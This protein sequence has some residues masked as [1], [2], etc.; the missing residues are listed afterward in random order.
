MENSDKQHVSIVIAGHIDAGKSSFTGRLLYDMGNISQRE[1]DKLQAEADALGKGSF[2]FAFYTDNQKAERERGITINYNC[3]DF[4]T[5]KYHYT[6]IDAP[7]HRDFVK[8][9][10]SGSSTADTAIIMVPADS[11]TVAMAKKNKDEGT[12]EGQ[13]RQHSLILYLLGIKQLIVQVNK[14]DLVNYSEEKFNEIKAEVQNMLINVGW[15]KPFVMNNVPIIPISAWHGDNLL[16]PS[17]NMPW[18]TGSKAKNSAGEI[19]NVCTTMDALETFVQPPQRF[20]ER[21]LRLCVSNIYNI[22]GTGTVVAGR[23]EQ[24]S[25][26]PNDQVVFLPRHTDTLPC[27]GRVFAI[28]MHHKEYPSA[29]P[30]DNVGLN[31]KGLTKENMPKAGDVMILDSDKTLVVPE[32]IRAQ[33]KVLDCPNEIKIGYTPIITARTAKAPARIAEICWRMNKDTGGQKI[34]NPGFLK[35]NDNAEVIFVPQIP[36][37]VEEF[38]N[39]EGLGRFCGLESNTVAMIG[40]VIGIEG[41]MDLKV[42]TSKATPSKAT[43]KTAKSAPK[44]NAN[45]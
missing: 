29:G 22:K 16:A 39:C 31:I 18:F 13:T 20:A 28:E 32:R 34:E 17:Q 21:P 15:P 3:K 43:G 2:V 5:N 35:A 42:E 23:I 44:A 8:N 27:R 26:K 40:K 37:V 24:G 33:I 1:K 11:F 19:V 7:G 10:I 25:I 6:I 4:Y 30:G 12:V 38:V 9:M 14:M 41:K 45:C 36:M